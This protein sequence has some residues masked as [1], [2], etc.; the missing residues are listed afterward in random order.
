M[1]SARVPQ[2]CFYIHQE[3]EFTPLHR[4]LDEFNGATLPGSA[5]P[6]SAHSRASG[7]ARLSAAYAHF[8]G[9]R[10]AKPG[11]AQRGEPKKPAASQ[12]VSDREEGL[13]KT[14]KEQFGFIACSSEAK[15]ALRVAR[16]VRCVRVAR[17]CPRANPAC[18][19]ACVAESET[20]QPGTGMCFSTKTTWRRRALSWRS[21]P[22][23]SL[24]WGSTG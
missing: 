12:Y 24:R 19:P 8:G 11:G 6:L 20:R 21:A 10:D 23:L 17:H 2:I 4:S 3:C 13:V 1:C 16:P 9:S 18:Q 15:C 14:L 22:S 5:A 7:D